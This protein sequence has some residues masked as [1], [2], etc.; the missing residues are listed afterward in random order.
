M[1]PKRHLEIQ[2][3]YVIS[4][5]P[6]YKK[7][8]KEYL[9]QMRHLLSK[10]ELAEEATYVFSAALNQSGRASLSYGYA[11]WLTSESTK[12]P[13][14]FKDGGGGKL[15]PEEGVFIFIFYFQLTYLGF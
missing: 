3:L 4:K 15:P 11:N 13:W 10:R 9:S 6:I 2:S 14:E 7:E 8:T 5:E 12:P 1:D